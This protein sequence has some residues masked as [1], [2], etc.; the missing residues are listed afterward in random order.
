MIRENRAASTVLDVCLF[1]L[2]VGGAVATLA[3]LPAPDDHRDGDRAD[4]TATAL[5]RTTATVEY[6]LRPPGDAGL[7]V[8]PER[9]DHDTVAG[10]LARAAVVDATLDGE[11]LDPSRREFVEAVEERTAGLLTTLVPDASVGVTAV[12]RP[13]E[14]APLS[15]RVH[16][17]DRPPGDADV[18]AATVSVPSGMAVDRTTLDD[19]RSYEA[20]A[21]ALA[22]AAIRG[23]YPAAPTRRTLRGDGATS[24]VATGRYAHVASLLGTDVDG[25]LAVGRADR[26]NER[27]I[28]A[29]ASV[30]V[31]D[32]RERFADPAAATAAVRIDR[33][34]IVVRT[35]SA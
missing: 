7:D 32:L 25:P 21:R 26:V 1:C 18:H 24:A 9:T 22:A 27:L 34:T 2:L 20:V 19:P 6:E 4:E 16:A 35:W 13:Y 28:D 8:G 29:L 14:G 31:A 15:G 11:R 5:G 30:L 23:S 10:L 33:V 12:W 3:T 17:G